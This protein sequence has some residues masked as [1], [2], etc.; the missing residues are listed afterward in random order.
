LVEVD[1]V[2]TT[3]DQV[4]PLFVEK[5]TRYSVIAE[6]PVDVGAV[7]FRATAA[8][9]AVPTN[10]VG[11][12]GTLAALAGPAPTRLASTSTTAMV[13]AMRADWGRRIVLLERDAE[14]VMVS[15]DWSGSRSSTTGFGTC[16]TALD[17][18]HPDG[19]SEHRPGTPAAAVT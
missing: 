13:A 4:D 1:L 10:P 17:H 14:W 16:G 6:P 2:R 18:Q 9:A 11:A 5:R 15:P 19:A 8:S 3:L 7:H 12:P